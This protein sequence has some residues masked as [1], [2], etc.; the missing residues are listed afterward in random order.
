M[1]LKVWKLHNG[2]PLGISIP[3]AMQIQWRKSWPLLWSVLLEIEVE[4]VHWGSSQKWRVDWGLVEKIVR[5]VQWTLVSGRD[6]YFVL[7]YIEILKWFFPELCMLIG[8]D[9]IYVGLSRRLSL[10]WRPWWP[11]LIDVDLLS[12]WLLQIHS[13]QWWLWVIHH[14]VNLIMGWYLH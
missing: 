6:L 2:V 1:P 10:A 3:K 14:L 9:V 13:I 5:N 12:S 4:F 7:N 11:Y 8:L